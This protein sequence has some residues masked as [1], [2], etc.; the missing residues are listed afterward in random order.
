VAGAPN[1]SAGAATAGATGGAGEETAGATG[2][3]GAG[4][5]GSAGASTAGANGVAGSAGAATAGAGGAAGSGGSAGAATA[6]AGGKAGAG[7]SAGAATAGSGGAV[8]GSGGSAGAATAGSGGV[9]GSSGS[10]GAATGGTGG[11]A[12]NSGNAGSAGAGGATCNAFAQAAPAISTNDGTGFAPTP[13]YGTITAGTYYLTQETFYPGAPPHSTTSAAAT[14]KITVAS[15]V[16]TLNVVVSDGTRYTLTITMA[17][18]STG[19]PTAEAITCTSNAAVTGPAQSVTGAISYT[20]G[21]TT[22]TTYI[23][24]YHLLAVYTLQP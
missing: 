18:P 3:A 19:A 11:T 10:A 6:G 2:S 22:L 13:T 16:A 23:P 12:G 5:A 20:M 15:Q 17:N 7:G 9:G 21:T 4:T 1:S 8:G 14:M 24:L